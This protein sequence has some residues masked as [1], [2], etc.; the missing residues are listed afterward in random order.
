MRQQQDIQGK[1][2]TVPFVNG[3]RQVRQQEFEII[4][5]NLRTAVLRRRGPGTRG[6]EYDTWPI[7]VVEEWIEKN[8]TG[9]SE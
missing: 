2:F 3:K 8:E 9:N 7:R 6:C 5:H 1:R 4:K